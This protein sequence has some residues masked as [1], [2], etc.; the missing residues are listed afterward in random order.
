MDL[1]TYFYFVMLMSLIYLG[2]MRYLQNRFMPKNIMA[3]V[4]EKSKQL[5]EIN[6]QNL[7]EARKADEIN[8]INAELLP[9]MNQMMMGQFKMMYVILIIFSAFTWFVGYLDPTSLDDVTFNLTNQGNYT[10][11]GSY[12]IQQSG[13]PLWYA[14]FNAYQNSTVLASNQ[15]AFFVGE[16]TEQPLWI[17]TSGLPMGV[18][19]DRQLYSIG[20]NVTLTAHAPENST[21][22]S[23]TLNMGTRFYVDLPVTIPLLNIRRIYDSQGWFVFLT[24]VLGLVLNLILSKTGWGK[25]A[26]AKKA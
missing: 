2:I 19:T 23:A 21:S 20:E 12:S 9:K 25:P 10:F 14:T 3:E 4:Q 26:E 24:F 18:G 22:V 1:N 11:T 8:K 17:K 13:S 16:Q 6:R 5:S 7:S 15:S